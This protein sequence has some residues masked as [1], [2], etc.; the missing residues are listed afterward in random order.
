MRAV[1]GYR[2]IQQVLAQAVAVQGHRFD[3]VAELI[4]HS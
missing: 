1:F 2:K 3:L 4:K